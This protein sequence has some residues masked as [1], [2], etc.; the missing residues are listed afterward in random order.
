ME[1]GNMRRKEKRKFQPMEMTVSK[2]NILQR[3]QRFIEDHR[4]K[5]TE[6]QNM[7]YAHTNKKSDR[8]RFFSCQ[9]EPVE[10]LREGNNLVTRKETNGQ[11]ILNSDPQL[12]IFL[13]LLRSSSLFRCCNSALPS[14][15]KGK[16]DIYCLSGSPLVLRVL[17]F[18]DQLQTLF[19]VQRSPQEAAYYL[20]DQLLTGFD[21]DKNFENCRQVIS[22]GGLSLLLRRVETGDVSEKCKVASVMYYCVQSDGSSELLCIDKQVQKNRILRGLLWL[23]NGEHPAP[24]CSISKELNKKNPPIILQALLQLDLLVSPFSLS[25]LPKESL[26][27]GKENPQHSQKEILSLVAAHAA[28]RSERTRALLI[29]GSCFSYA[30][31]PV[32]EQCL[33]KEAGY[34]ENTGNSYLGKNLIL[35]SYTNLNEEE[36]ATRNWQRKT[37]IVLLNSGNKRLLAG[38]VDSIAN[39]IPC[40]G[41]ASLVTVTWMSNFFCFIEDKGVQSLV[42][43]ELIP[44]LMKLLKYNNA[45]EERVLA[46]LSL[47][48]L[49]DNSDYLAKLSPLD[50]ELISDLHK[51]SEATWTAKELISIISS[52]SRH[53]QLNVP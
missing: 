38:L 51:L 10:F 41:R 18:A 29:L 39:G 36:E 15:A 50:K 45:I 27:R 53:Q 42:Y 26:G 34:D 1:F 49:A 48:K 20:L 32:V 23:G 6:L 17:E 3:K 5:A 40:L 44:E 4:V 21:E 22:L 9:S 7:I 8:F 33:L 30:G 2:A 52:S 11:I 35:N 16:T 31:E 25:S 14:A 47:L 43:S 13:R 46:S 24:S 28:V 37:A 12:D 19:T